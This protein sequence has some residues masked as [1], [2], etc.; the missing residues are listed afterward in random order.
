MKRV[1]ETFQLVYRQPH[2]VG[3]YYE[4]LRVG[5]PSEFDINLELQLPIS[6]SHIEVCFITIMLKFKENTCSN[7]IFMV[8]M[9]VAV[10][11]LSHHSW[12]WLHCA[13]IKQWKL[14]NKIYRGGG[15]GSGGGSGGIS[16]ASY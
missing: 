11:V 14:S 4:N 10:A 7:Q 9:V 2:Y 1:D 8:V 15:G 6:E 12:L 16:V 5:H 3:S 13:K